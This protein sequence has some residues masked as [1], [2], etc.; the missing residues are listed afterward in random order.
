MSRSKGK[1]YVH[2]GLWNAETD[3]PI[4]AGDRV[5][6]TGC[7]ATVIVV[8]VMIVKVEKERGEV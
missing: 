3:E 6:L 7:C 5:I 4:T 8:R 2:G 1:V